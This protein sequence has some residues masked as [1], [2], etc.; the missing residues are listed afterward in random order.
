M[1]QARLATMASGWMASGTGDSL[2]LLN[3]VSVINP[4][5]EPTIATRQGKLT[6]NSDTTSYYDGGWQA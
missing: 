6:Y 3:S 5:A 2:C 1:L 4:V